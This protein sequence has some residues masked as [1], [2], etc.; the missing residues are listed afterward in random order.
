M[1]HCAARWFKRLQD[2][3][4]PVQLIDLSHMNKHE[5]P[6]PRPRPGFS[7][8]VLTVVGDQDVE[9]A[10]ETARHFGQAEAVELKGVAHDL[11]MV[12]LTTALHAVA[13]FTNGS[14]ENQEQYITV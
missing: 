7:T 3:I 1:F 6:L 10:E 2:N 4:S 13:M 8:P 12:R 9:A 11:M 14:M 5:L